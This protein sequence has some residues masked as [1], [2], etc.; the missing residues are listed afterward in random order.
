MNGEEHGQ[1]RELRRPVSAVGSQHRNPSR[2]L[3]P[4]FET[5]ED[6]EESIRSAFEAWTRPNFQRENV[7]PCSHSLHHLQSMFSSLIWLNFWCNFK[8]WQALF[9]R[10]ELWQF[11]AAFPRSCGHLRAL[12]RDRAGTWRQDS[13]LNFNFKPAGKR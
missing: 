9:C 1:R 4:G 11:K 5:V 2:S 10:M 6:I 7:A 13:F 8:M 3:D 12:D